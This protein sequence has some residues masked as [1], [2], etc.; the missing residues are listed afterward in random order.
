MKKYSIGGQALIEGVMMRGPK[1][2][3]MAVRNSSGTIITQEW[4]NDSEK[5]S[6]ILKIPFVRGIFNFIDSMKI[7]YKT[8]MKSADIAMSYDED[9][10]NNPDYVSKDETEKDLHNNNESN[11]ESVKEKEESGVLMTIL[12]TISSMLGM[13]LAVALFVWLPTFLFNLLKTKVVAIDT[14]F[15]Q[16]L[17][18]GIFS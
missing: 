6:T 8:L 18:E 5:K 3:A 4:E 9:D 17:F 1:K 16:A 13:V 11:N 15:Y 12:M 7:G 14:R 2:I 10:I